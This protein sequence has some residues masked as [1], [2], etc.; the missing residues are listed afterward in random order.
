MGCGGI[1]SHG[2]LR[3]WALTF[4]PLTVTGTI[5]SANLPASAAALARE[6]LP[7]HSG[8]YQQKVKMT[9]S[10]HPPGQ[11]SGSYD[12]ILADKSPT[13]AGQG[14]PGPTNTD[15][16]AYLPTAKASCCSRVNL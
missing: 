7:G 1:A 15:G 11:C 3:L 2:G 9:F 16:G 5:S 10:L 13:G 4:L 6:K 8:P 14:R 12:R